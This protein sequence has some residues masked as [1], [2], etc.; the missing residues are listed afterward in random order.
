MEN[1]NTTHFKQ[2]RLPK[3]LPHYLEIVTVNGGDSTSQYRTPFAAAKFTGKQV[4]IKP[5]YFL[6]TPRTTYWFIIFQLSFLNTA[7]FEFL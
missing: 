3:S 6:V 4:K 5:R 2:G 7:R 1:K